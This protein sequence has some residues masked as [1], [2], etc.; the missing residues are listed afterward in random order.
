MTLWLRVTSLRRAARDLLA[1]VEDDHA[2]GE[3]VDHLHDV[4]DDDQRD[5]GAR[6]SRAPARWRGA[7]RWASVPAIAS[8]S[9][10]TFGSVASARAISRRLRPGV[11]RLLRRRMRDRRQPDAL[12]D[13]LRPRARFRGIGRAQ[14]RADHDVLEH[15]HALERQRHLER[16]RDAEL[17]ALLRRQARD[18]LTFE[19]AQCRRSAPGRR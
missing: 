12:D 1:L 17:R 9:S 6:G 13:R 8:S 18:V 10:S 2:L 11:P 15:R 16:A 5:P 3:R 14:E 4:L 7:P 19:A